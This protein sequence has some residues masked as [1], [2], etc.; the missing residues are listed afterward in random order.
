MNP[1]KFFWERD[2]D[3]IDWAG[4]KIKKLKSRKGLS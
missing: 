2:F 1:L 4:R 3:Y